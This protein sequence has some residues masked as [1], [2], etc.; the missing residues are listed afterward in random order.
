M[1]ANKLVPT[2]IV[3]EVGVDISRERY[4]E[5]VLKIGD[6]FS[7]YRDT[8]APNVVARQSLDACLRGVKPSD[9]TQVWPGAQNAT[10]ASRIK[11][12]C[13][14]NI[15]TMQPLRSTN[16]KGL[17]RKDLERKRKLKKQRE[18]FDDPHLPKEMRAELKANATYGHDAR[19]HFTEPEH[20]KWQEL[21]EA[22]I[23]EFPELATVNAQS[24]LESLCDLLVLQERYR[25]SAASGKPQDAHAVSDNIKLISVLKDAMN[26]HPKQVAKRVEVST[27]GTVG[28][29]VARMESMQGRA[30]LQ[31][32]FFLEELLLLY[33]MY[34]TPSPRDDTGGYQI[35]EVGLFGVTKCA[36]CHCASC[37]T[38]NFRG[39]SVDEIET[40]LASKGVIEPVSES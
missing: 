9:P 23:A 1:K 19:I 4:D 13:K 37:G 25:F 3:Y 40:H 12:V 7:E 17:R 32:K 15:D 34:H 22:Y 21:K 2:P 31:A 20:K 38:H 30:E 18:K 10:L 35:D 39:L 24:E 6:W 29:A 8:A 27:S 11:Q 33:Q 5:L 16:E 26:I 36:T 28:E 14:F